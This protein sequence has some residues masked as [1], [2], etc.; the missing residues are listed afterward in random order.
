MKRVLTRKS[1]DTNE[2]I[3]SMKTNILDKFD[4]YWGERNL[5]ISIA[6]VLD[7]RNKMKFLQYA[8]KALY[9]AIDAPMYMD[10]LRASLYELFEEYVKAYRAMVVEKNS[11]YA[12]CSLLGT[13]NSCPMHFSPVE[14]RDM[15]PSV[16]D[17]VSSTATSVDEVGESLS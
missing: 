2:Y 1:T 14:E 11:S 13:Y 16:G 17:V 15:T 3:K 4:K 9:S 6:A 8:Y 7:P 12:S 10:N 5:L